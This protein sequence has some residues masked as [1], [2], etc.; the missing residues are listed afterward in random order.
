L[1][2]RPKTRPAKLPLD[3]SDLNILAAELRRHAQTAADHGYYHSLA[4]LPCRWADLEALLDERDARAR[5]LT[6]LRR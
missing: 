5:A 3:F 6:E 4:V 1:S 2:A